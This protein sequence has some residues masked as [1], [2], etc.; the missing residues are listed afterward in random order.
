[1]RYSII[2]FEGNTYIID[3]ESECVI[4][5]GGPSLNKPNESVVTEKLKIKRKKNVVS[6]KEKLLKKLKRK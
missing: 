1:M 5:E 3:N 6:N 4:A 2:K